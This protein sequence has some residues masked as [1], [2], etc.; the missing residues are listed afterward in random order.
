[1]GLAGPLRRRS[2]LLVDDNPIN[3]KVA[4]MFLQPFG[5]VVTEAVNGREA[6]DYL[7]AAAFD[8]E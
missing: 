3:R 5:V 6:L 4:S 1:M 8:A 7:A 2:V